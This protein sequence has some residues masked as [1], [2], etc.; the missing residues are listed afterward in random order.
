MVEAERWSYA[1]SHDIPEFFGHFQRALG[2]GVN[3]G[4]PAKSES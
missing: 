1:Y 3:E 4:S 2:K